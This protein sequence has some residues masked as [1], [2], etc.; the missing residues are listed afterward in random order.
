MA[1]KFVFCVLS[2]AIVFSSSV[3]AVTLDFRHG[4]KHHTEQHANR[5]K[6]SD[7]IGMFYY[8]LESKFASQEEEDGSQGMFSD[9]ERGDSEVDWGF[10]YSLND[11]WYIQPG[12]PVAFGDNKYSLKPQFRVGYRFD[13]MPLTTTLRYRRQFTYYTED[14]GDDSVKNKVTFKI[15]FSPGDYK[16]WLET[17]YV[18]NEDQ[19]IFDNGR[20]SY[21]AILG[22]GRRLGSWFPYVE[23]ADVGVSSDSDTRQL[24][25]RV[26]IKYYY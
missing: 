1:K 16:Y 5:V 19:D 2:S 22:A 12:M 24:R 26:G 17:N 15:G 3:G 11:N 7:S 20:E 23:F 13:D 10:K 6:V 18:Y 21:D 8:G 9:L 4:F 14:E 25:S